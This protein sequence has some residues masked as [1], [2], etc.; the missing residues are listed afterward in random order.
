MKHD[1]T[2]RHERE[3]M[4]LLT[5][6]QKR[7]L[8]NLLGMGRGYVLDLSN[9]DFADLFHEISVDIYSDT[10]AD[11]GNSKSNR[12]R[13]FWEKSSADQLREILEELARYIEASDKSD[14]DTASH[15]REIAQS[16]GN[17][18]P[19]TT[20]T[21]KTSKTSPA[22]YRDG[23]VTLEIHPDLF[24]HVKTFLHAGH[25]YTAVEESYK[26][27]RAC[28]REI[29]GEEAASKVFDNGAQ[30]RKF[31]LELFGAAEPSSAA[32]GNFLRGIGYLHL[33]VQ[34]L[35]NEKSH[36]PATDLDK[37]LALHYVSLAS[38]AYDL[39]TNSLDEAEATRVEEAITAARQKYSAT[40][41]YPAFKNA[42]WTTHLPEFPCLSLAYRR[43]LLKD[44]WLDAADFTRS[45]DTSNIHWMRLYLVRD[46][47]S[48]K[49]VDILLSKPSLD[50]H[51]NDQM[52][53]LGDFLK[54]LHKDHPE[55]LSSDA[56][57]RLEKLEA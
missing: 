54:I 15:L 44:R 25:Y 16:I 47:L 23:V 21:P 56:I 28:L 9:T 32:E 55:T 48:S 24:A 49:D 57:E 53:G 50:R 11:R 26:F 35:R 8:A 40:K 3:N 22:S 45:Y 43:R 27:V 52:A 7:A 20:Q 10:Y 5:F 19:A 12:M 51:G 39:I 37:N 2:T 33:A 1:E 36:T 17:H 31:Y 18:E 13:S 30:S 41:F 38:L 34:H 42:T 14:L 6:S 46:Q 4:D 29:T